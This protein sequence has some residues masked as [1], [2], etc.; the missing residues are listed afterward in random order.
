MGH[1]AG[2]VE[3]IGL[4]QTSESNKLTDTGYIPLQH[5]FGHMV[6]FFA[7]VSFCMWK[8]ATRFNVHLRCE[9]GK[10]QEPKTE[11]RSMVDTN[12]STYSLRAE[13]TESKSRAKSQ[14]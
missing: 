4:S 9:H 8:E 1:K 11:S 13:I 10:I 6:R 7:P 14:R 5:E 2:D 12:V 3:M